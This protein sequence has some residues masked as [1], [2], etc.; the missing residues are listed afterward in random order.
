M[1]VGRRKKKCAIRKIS[2]KRK[3]QEAS[4][5]M[6]PG[7]V[8]AVAPGASKRLL[9]VDSPAPARVTRAKASNA[10]KNES[11]LLT[12][13]RGSSLPMDDALLYMDEESTVRMDLSP[14]AT[15][16]ARNQDFDAD[17]EEHMDL[18]PV[19][20]SQDR[21]QHFDVESEQREQL[22]SQGKFILCYT[23]LLLHL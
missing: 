14:V 20:P 6:A 22:V 21:D 3:S 1:K 7:R 2:K 15:T 19:A 12:K 17:S 11:T 23:E 16:R 9:E 8:M 18:S 5:T 4:S 13:D 10:T